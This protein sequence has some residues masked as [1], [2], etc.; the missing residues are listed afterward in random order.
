MVMNRQT[1]VSSFSIIHSQL[2]IDIWLF[3]AILKLLSIN[4]RLFSIAKY[5]IKS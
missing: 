3:L 4:F 5:N 2:S 1:T